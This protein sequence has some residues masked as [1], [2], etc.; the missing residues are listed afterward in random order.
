M[1]KGAPVGTFI[2]GGSPMLK[3]IKRDS[4]R[5]PIIS[6]F[7]HFPVLFGGEHPI[8]VMTMYII[9][10]SFSQDVENEQNVS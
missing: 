5:P 2:V 8:G 9:Y 4:G 1:Q 6:K 3:N 7:L 10:G